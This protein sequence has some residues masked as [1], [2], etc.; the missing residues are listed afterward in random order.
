LDMSKTEIFG[1][2]NILKIV[3]WD[4]FFLINIAQQKEL[5]TIIWT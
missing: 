3:A 5:I 1:D 2:N 4:Q